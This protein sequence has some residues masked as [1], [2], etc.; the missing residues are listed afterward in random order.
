MSIFNAVHRKI[1]SLVMNNFSRVEI[2]T[3]IFFNGKPR[4]SNIFLA[5]TKWMEWRENKNISSF[6]NNLSTFPKGMIFPGFFSPKIFMKA[7]CSAIFFIFKFCRRDF[8][9]FM[10]FKTFHCS[11]HYFRTISEGLCNVLYVFSGKYFS[12]VRNAHLYFRFNGM[13]F[14]F[15]SKGWGTTFQRT[16]FSPSLFYF[17]WSYF[18]FISTSLTSFSSSFI[19]FILASKWPRHIPFLFSNIINSLN[20]KSRREFCPLNFTV[21]T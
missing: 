5:I 17:I 11:H 21:K 9:I 7:L 14:P 13:F 20:L 4:F 6:I 16:I 1:Y 8:Y 18:K 19:D 12:F 3:Q 10:T 15:I 2:M